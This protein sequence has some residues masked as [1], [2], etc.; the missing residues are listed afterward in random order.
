MEYSAVWKQSLDESISVAKRFV[1]DS[2]LVDRCNQF[3]LSLIQTFEK[4]GKVFICGN[5]GSHCDAMH[6]A[7]E[8]TGRFKHDRPPFGALAL[9]DPS[10]IT[11][12]GNDYGFEHVFSRQLEGLA[13]KG[14]LFIVLSTSGES[15]NI[16]CALEKAKDLSLETVALLGKGGGKAKDMADLV[17]VVPADSSERVQEVH[18]KLL[19]TVIATIEM[20]FGFLKKS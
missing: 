1:S 11:C 16:L 6:F 7:E 14:D 4:K 12:V 20:H 13:R 3:S 10:H 15:P 19:H 18:I 9:G 8:L 2:Q 5:G 17:L